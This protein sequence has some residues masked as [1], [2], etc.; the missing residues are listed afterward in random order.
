MGA[1][2]LGRPRG[3]LR[4]GFL[5]V[6]SSPEAVVVVV[7]RGL[8]FFLGGLVGRDDST[9]TLLAGGSGRFTGG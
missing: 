5:A 3:F 2:F 9:L 1:S 4:A 7:F 8:P 6:V